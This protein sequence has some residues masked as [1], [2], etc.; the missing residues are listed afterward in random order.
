MTSSHK[1]NSYEVMHRP[2]LLSEKHVSHDKKKYQT[3]RLPVQNLQEKSNSR[4]TPSEN[5]YLKMHEKKLVFF[6]KNEKIRQSLETENNMCK[7][8]YSK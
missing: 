8:Y 3:V 7:H 6:K 5:P 2:R 4:L 1:K